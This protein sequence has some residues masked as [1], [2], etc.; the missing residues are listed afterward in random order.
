MPAHRRDPQASSLQKFIN[1]F[2]E[3]NEHYDGTVNH[4]HFLSFATE[5][6]TNE[7]YTY[8]QAMKQPD[9]LQFVE[10]ME[11][12]IEDHQSRN[13]WTVVH[14]STVPLNAKP[15]KAIWS[16]KRKRRPDG[17]LLKHKARI[18]AHGGMQ[19]WGDNYWETYSPVVNMMSVRLLLV[20]AKIYKLDSKAI[21]FVLAFPQAELDTDI[22]M[23]LPIGFQVD[24][25]TEADSDRFYLL[26]LNKSLYGLKQGSFNWYK[27][28]KKGLEDRDFKPS[29]VDPCLYLRKDMIILTYVDD[30]IIVGK[31]TKAIDN[32]VE[33]LK[34]GPEN[35]IL[36]DEGDIDKFLG[37]NIAHLDKNRF[38]VTQP[39]LTER[40]ISFLGLDTNEFGLATNSKTTPVG[41]PILNKDLEGKPRK[42]SW[43]YRTA[44]GMLTYL[45]GNSRPE[46]AM[47]VHQTAR[48]SNNPKLC[49][50]KAIQRLGRYLLH[51]KDKGIIYSPDTS[52]GL[53]CYV[54]ADFA[55]GW[56]QS[57]A[58]DAET[59]MSRTGFV[60]MYA[61]CPVYWK[62]S[63]QTEIALSTAEA[64]YIAL[65]QALREVIPLMTLF[66]EI[67]QTFPMLI[68]SPNFVCKV[69]E[70][71]Q[72]CIRMA[73]SEKF[74]PRTKHIALKYHHFRSFL[75]AEK[76]QLSYCRTEDQKAGIL[77]KPLP[78]KIFFKLRY[79][80]NGW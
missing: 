60:I 77:T 51:T 33:S 58:E 20:I 19:K 2:E 74:T 1:K 26:K 44:V 66:E 6:S 62:S 52:K 57:D 36:T 15:I 16:F 12:E 13:H 69:H 48:F 21:D 49:H 32:L 23:Y 38:E 35:F 37:I 47:A 17:S 59:V 4:L 31:S 24:G 41:R 18:C 22:W 7:V 61:N 11:K 34:N 27:K 5:T 79:M 29:E 72:S 70:D 65:S 75:K 30:C 64:E 80:L 54:D 73:M 9:K 42:C 25:Q 46:I 68:Q 8:N 3:L 71:N 14:R 39:H 10:A 55:G 78:D 40:I 63:L 53:E 50:E 76:L 67:N 43:N 28:L 56:S 45:Q